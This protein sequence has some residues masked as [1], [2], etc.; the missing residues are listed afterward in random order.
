MPNLK[1][2]YIFGG[3]A[4]ITGFPEKT[5]L[6][7]VLMLYTKIDKDFDFHIPHMMTKDRECDNVPPIPKEEPA[8][9]DSYRLKYG[10]WGI[11]QCD[12]VQPPV[13]SSQKPP[14]N[15]TPEIID[16]MMGS[17]FGSALGDALGI[18]EEA[19]G[20]KF[21]HF[22][23][24]CPLDISWSHIVDPDEYERFLIGET[25]DDTDQSV[26]IMRSLK[27]GKPDVLHFA[28]EMKTWVYDGIVEHKHGECYDCGTTT[29]MTIRNRL[30]LKDP[31]AAAK[32][33]CNS[34]A[35]GN[36]SAM[37]TA[38]VGCFHFWNENEVKENAKLFASATHA[39]PYCVQAAVCVSLLISRFIQ[40]RCGMIADVDVEA[41]L[42]ESIEFVGSEDHPFL[43]MKDF[44]ELGVDGRQ[45]GFVMKALGVALI[46]LRNNWTYEEAMENV[47]A[48]GGDTDTNAA[49]VG[50][51]LGAKYGFSSIPKKLIKYLFNGSWIYKDFSQMLA[52]MGIQPPASPFDT[53]SYE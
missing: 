46:C 51:I 26:F 33:V 5:N 9:L 27:T 30:F 7:C 24:Q 17:V 52:A 13:F 12:L 36:G 4:D 6:Q 10:P 21:I 28:K 41:T 48:G 40:K 53:L 8:W 16:S 31:C 44:D 19:K 2:L 23:C 15:I 1:Y 29:H 45:C 32:E 22:I 3:E 49:I 14:F 43:H 11:P 35:V 42:Q 37:R 25:T 20:T 39:H 47:V 50:A 18:R 38:S 34:S